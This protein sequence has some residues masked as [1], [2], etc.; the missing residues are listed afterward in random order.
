VA[1]RA[2]VATERGGPEVLELRNVA[3][4]WPRGRG[5]VLV[6][7]KAAAVNPADAYFRR[8]GPYVH[9]ERP[10]IPGH[11]GAG[12][13]EAVGSLVRRFKPGDAVC[14]C[15]GGIGDQ[16]GT[17]A[18][19]AVVP[20][21]QLV[22]KPEGVDFL[23]AAALPLVAITLSEALLERAKVRR[24]D[25]VLI[26]AG[27]GGTGHV[28][29]QLARLAGAHVATTVSTP[30]KAKLAAELGA[31]LV[32]A[33]RERDFV[34]ATRHWTNGRGLDVALD[35]VGPEVMQRT[36]SAMRPY[37]RVVTLMGTPGDTADGAAYNG[38]LTI[39]NV[40][41]LTPMW[42]GLTAVLRHQADLAHRAINLLASGKLR[43]VIDRVF[44]LSEAAA[45]HRRLESGESIGKIV[46]AM[47]DG[48]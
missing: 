4:P 43:I 12:E 40:M 27:A 5:D 33:Y 47:P 9:P 16:A 2:I 36:F 24:G 22:H 35:N 44:P 32:I 20:S 18:E 14:F 37:G 46:L 15:N 17:Y 41:M 13:V 42:R 23:Q 21:G 29:I 34:A 31:E 8:F 10:F 19:Y 7:L 38:N 26:H 39:H 11:D 30:A 25:H 6:R 3:L 1:M 48:A 45:A 28:G